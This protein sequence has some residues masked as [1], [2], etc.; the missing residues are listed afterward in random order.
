MGKD[1]NVAN[2]IYK[3]L[4]FFACR[5]IIL[6]KEHQQDISRYV[7]CNEF[8]IPPFDGPYS[9]QPSRWVQKSFIIKSVLNSRKNISSDKSKDSK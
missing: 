4:P 3:Q 5:N 2:S 9:S 1:F 8:G 6:N 7:Y